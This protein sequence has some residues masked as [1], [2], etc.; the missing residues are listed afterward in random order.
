[1]VILV[2]VLKF[3]LNI[4][5]WCSF[6]DFSSLNMRLSYS[7]PPLTTIFGL[8]QNAMGKP[9]LHCCSD[10]K[11]IKKTQSE[12]M[13]NFNNLKFSIIINDFGE[14]IEDFINIHKGSREL[15]NF[16]SSLKDYLV[17]LIDKSN[18]INENQLPNKIN[19]LKKFKFYNDIL[20]DSEKSK[21][22]LE[23][24]KENN[25]LLIIEE[26]KKFW[27]NNSKGINGYNLN[28]DW[29]STQIYKQKI[30]NP[31]FTIFISSTDLNG[32]W[33]IQNI[34]KCLKN[35]KRPLY[36]GES[37]DM[38][39]ITNI[40]IVDVDKIISSNISSVLLGVYNNSELV[41][42]PLNLKYAIDN[43]NKI[44]S[45]PK[46]NLDEQI[47]CYTYNGENFVFL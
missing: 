13:D 12:Y 21:E 2:E 6:S 4:P 27:F 44:C 33:S 34:M 37:D 10:N 19:D 3:N 38:V 18:I 15:E 28:K 17:K 35:P 16:E 7:F 1:M 26:I 42:V 47:D 24:Y 20:L 29:I 25:C 30:I 45:I 31:N 32:E 36:I 41:K 8:I 40:E 22:C 46:G 14:K 9:A 5:F 39:D 23:L 11:I 43:S